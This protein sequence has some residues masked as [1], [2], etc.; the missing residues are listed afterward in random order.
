MRHK[1]G[2]HRLIKLD[3]IMGFAAGMEIGDYVIAESSSWKTNVSVPPLPIKG[4]AN[5]AR[6]ISKHVIAAGAVT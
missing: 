4:V 3:D 6:R 1:I 2:K 5:S